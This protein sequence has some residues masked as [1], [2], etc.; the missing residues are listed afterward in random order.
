MSQHSHDH[1]HDHSHEHSHSHGHHHT[2]QEFNTAFLIAIALNFIFVIVEVMFAYRANSMS[3]LADAGHNL[4]DVLGLIMAWV[5]LVLLAKKASDKYSYG[6]KRTTI[7]AAIGNAVFL[8]ATTI[9]IFYESLHKILHPQV[10][11]ELQVMV[12]AAF[13][14]AINGG[15]A[16]LFAKGQDDLN[17]KAAFLHLAYDA[18]MSLGVVLTGAVVLWT[19]WQVLDP[20]VAFVIAGF[21][22]YGAWGLLRD[23]VDLILDA[24]PTH[25]NQETVKNF[26]S[27][28]PGIQEVH[29]IH[30]WGLSTK[31]V[32]LTAHL[33]VPAGMRDDMLHDLHHILSHEFG[34]QHATIQSEKESCK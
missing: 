28:Y 29:H 34:I 8:I 3:L 26:F 1:S 21:I 6:F 31:E 25:I 19:G 27:N 12:V 18:V 2:P 24:V 17:I 23:S 9:L 11:R 7:L 33:V 20:I 14:I 32:A 15:T 30:I 4:G 10:I 16:F 22:L 13:G 5:A